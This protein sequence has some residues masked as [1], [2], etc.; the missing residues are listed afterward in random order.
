[1]TTTAQETLT[2]GMAL[3]SHPNKIIVKTFGSIRKSANFVGGT[4]L[5]TA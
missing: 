1:M 5:T 4:L 2:R 3:I